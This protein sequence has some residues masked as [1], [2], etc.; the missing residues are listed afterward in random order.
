[1]IAASLASLIPLTGSNPPWDW[2]RTW[3]AGADAESGVRCNKWRGEGG[4][5]LSELRINSSSASE[6]FS[7]DG[8]GFSICEG[9]ENLP[10]APR[11]ETTGVGLNVISS[12]IALGDCGGFIDLALD[13]ETLL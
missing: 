13:L 12:S 7:I 2:I 4:T 1:M 8:E 3:A 9:A 11:F 5:F 6:I 10:S